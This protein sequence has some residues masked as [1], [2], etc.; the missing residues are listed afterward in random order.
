MWFAY[1][2]KLIKDSVQMPDHDIYSVE[3]IYSLRKVKQK[4]VRAAPVFWKQEL[5]QWYDFQKEY[6]ADVTQEYKSG[7]LHDIIERRPK[8]LSDMFFRIKY[9]YRGLTYK[10]VSNVLPAFWPIHP[11]AIV[12]NMPIKEA[13]LVD[14][15]GGAQLDVTRKIKKCAGPRHNFH[16]ETPRVKDIFSLDL[17]EYS[18]LK[19][20]SLSNQTRVFDVHTDAITHPLFL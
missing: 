13:F 14:R 2:I 18:T 5:D 20:T 10:Y 1:M 15:D 17:S 8:N 12:F 19:V 7:E 6:W 11:K 4:Y 9:N 16:G 3:M